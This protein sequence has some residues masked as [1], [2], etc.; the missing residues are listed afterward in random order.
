ML[1]VHFTFAREYNFFSS[2]IFK[3][4]TKTKTSLVRND[5]A[6]ELK[7]CLSWELATGDFN[8]FSSLSGVQLSTDSEIPEKKKCF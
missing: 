2:H 5:N 4:K 3:L 8:R 6:C 1:F 7:E